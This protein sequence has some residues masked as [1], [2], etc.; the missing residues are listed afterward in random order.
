MLRAGGDR[1]ESTR[2]TSRKG[3]CRLQR[4]LPDGSKLLACESAC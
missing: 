1:M 2:E 4:L 3:G